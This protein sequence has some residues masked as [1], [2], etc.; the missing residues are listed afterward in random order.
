[1]DKISSADAS[2]VIRRAGT[3]LRKLA[4]R[5]RELETK[6]ARYEKQSRCEKIASAMSSKGMNGELSDEEKVASL[7]ELPEKE[8]D[9][10][11]K[12]VDLS[13]GD[14]LNMKAVPGSAGGENG[15]G[16]QGLLLNGAE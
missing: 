10:Y 9:V 1:M 15:G 11:E 6:V 4:S 13:P 8:L 16:L 14:G 7:M 3:S 5:N 2:Q 12:A